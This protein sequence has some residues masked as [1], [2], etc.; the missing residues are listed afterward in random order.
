MPLANAELYLDLLGRHRTACPRWGRLRTRAVPMERTLA[1]ACREA[2]A[3]VRVNAK[4]RDMNVRADD[5]R[6]TEVLAS[7]LP[8]LQT[9]CRHHGAFTPHLDRPGA[10]RGRNNGWC[11]A[12]QSPYR[13]TP[14]SSRK[15][16]SFGGGGPGDRG[17][18]T[19]WRQT[20]RARSPLSCADLPIL[21]DACGRGCWESCDRSFADS[22][23]SAKWDT[24]RG[25]EGTRPDLTDLF[26]EQWQMRVEGM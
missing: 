11:S 3:L 26:G 21:L 15:P 5:E 2:G 17:L 20:A 8:I 10:P 19:C 23:V 12:G 4:L 18:S 7:A 14:N 13:S 24:W 9:G 1:R 25:T 6:A 16:M 22:L